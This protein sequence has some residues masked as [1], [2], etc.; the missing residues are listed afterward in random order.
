MKNNRMP[1][2]SSG[3]SALG[4]RAPKAPDTVQCHRARHAAA[5][6]SCAGIADTKIKARFADLG[7]TAIGGSPA[8]FGNLIVDET[9]KWRRWSGRPTST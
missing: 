2:R 4:Q 8:D 5:G 7:G 1:S 3:S 6:E 9:E